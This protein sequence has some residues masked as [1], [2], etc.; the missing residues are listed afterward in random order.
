MKTKILIISFLAFVFNALGQVT[1]DIMPGKEEYAVNISPN[2]EYIVAAV[3]GPIEYLGTINDAYGT[4]TIPPAEGL[5]RVFSANPDGTF[6]MTTQ[7]VLPKGTHSSAATALLDHVITIDNAGNWAIFYQ[8]DHIGDTPNYVLLINGTEI[9]N[10]TE[11][12]GVNSMSITDGSLYLSGQASSVPFFKKYDVG[13]GN[14]LWSVN[15]GGNSP[16]IVKTAGDTLYIKMNF[17]DGTYNNLVEFDDTTGANLGLVATGFT[18]Y[19]INPAGE[20]EY[21]NLNT[22]VLTTSEGETNWFVNGQ[23]LNFFTSTASRADAWVTQI[24]G[25]RCFVLKGST[26]YSFSRKLNHQFKK[27]LV[28]GSAGNYQILTSKLFDDGSVTLVTLTSQYNNGYID[29]NKIDIRHLDYDSN[30]E[31]PIATLNAEGTGVASVHDGQRYINEWVNT[32]ERIGTLVLNGSMPNI[33]DVANYDWVVAPSGYTLFTTGLANPIIQGDNGDLF[34]RFMFKPTSGI[35]YQLYKV[36]IIPSSALAVDENNVNN[37]SGYYNQ[38]NQSFV[39][40]SQEEIKQGAIY[41]TLG[42]KIKLLFSTN[43]VF[44]GNLQTG[45]YIAQAITDSGKVFKKRFLKY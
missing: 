23:S 14:L 16:R 2:G 32:Y 1:P 41:N 40:H 26:L 36:Y 29:H 31:P 21:Y 20:I 3:D 8:D 35:E 42:Q 12:I 9:D 19:Q 39:I 28:P 30:N 17:D 45:V 22:D 24:N 43:E 7:V 5:L 34:V 6:S 37:L 4:I 38:D 18:K 27:N 11:S 15:P 44:L 33:G 10:F 13:T 25:N